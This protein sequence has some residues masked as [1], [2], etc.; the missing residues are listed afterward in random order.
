MI[1]TRRRCKLG[2]VH[3]RF[4]TDG[5]VEYD[6]AEAFCGVCLNGSC[7]TMMTPEKYCAVLIA[8]SRNLTSLWSRVRLVIAAACS[9]IGAGEGSPWSQAYVSGLVGSHHRS[10]TKGIVL[11]VRL[12]LVVSQ[13]LLE[14]SL[15]SFAVGI[16]SNTGRVT[17]FASL[18]SDSNLCVCGQIKIVELNVD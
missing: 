16:K 18:C 11:V 8:Q 2:D 17:S 13:V 5:E 3:K 15:E 12:S 1:L 4:C 10:N 7:V 9:R 14:G 6:Q